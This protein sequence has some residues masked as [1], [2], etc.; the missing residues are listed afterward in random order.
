MGLMDKF[1]KY[2]NSGDGGNDINFFTLKDDGDTADVRFLFTGEM[3]LDENYWE[4]VHKLKGELAI[5]GK[6]RTVAC[7]KQD[8]PLCKA[9][10]RAFPKIYLPLID[11]SDEKK[12]KVWERGQK[13]LGHFIKTIERNEPMFQKPMEVVRNGASGNP[14]TSYTIYPETESRAKDAGMW[15]EDTEENREKI[16]E[17][18]FDR[19]ELFGENNIVVV[20]GKEDLEKMAKGEFSFKDE[21][22]KK[23]QKS[24]TATTENKKKE[25]K[26][27]DIF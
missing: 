5:D 13:F 26:P 17:K 27:S 14:Q 16:K 19:D 6:Q 1:E 15:L 9:G 23:E 2:T 11:Y 21:K 12:L 24:N 18:R 20:R 7:L 8:C 22:E 4:V 3:D 10:D 25:E